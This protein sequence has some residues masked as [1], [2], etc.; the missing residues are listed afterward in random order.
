LTIPP[1]IPGTLVCNIIV[2]LIEPFSAVET[3]GSRIRYIKETQ[4]CFFFWFEENVN[5]ASAAAARTISWRQ[6]KRSRLLK[7]NRIVSSTFS[8]LYGH[9]NQYSTL[10]TLHYRITNIPKFLFAS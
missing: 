2:M 8:S 10:L 3:I 9:F 5:A 4:T 6:G 1:R 7:Q